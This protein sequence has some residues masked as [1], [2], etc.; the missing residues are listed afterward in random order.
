MSQDTTLPAGAL[1]RFLD[2]DV[3]YSFRRSP[4]AMVAA[5]TALLC[6]VAALGAPWLAPHD[7]YDL[8]AIDLA[9][10]RLPPAWMEGGSDRYWLGTDGQGRD[11]LSTIMYGTRISLFVGLAAV[12]ISV[13]LGVA[14]GLL[15]GF[16]GGRLDAF[17][18]RV[19]D[20]MLSFPA[21]LVAL[22]I[23][24][25]GRAMFPDAHDTLA[26]AV[27]ILA[28]AL[29]GWVKFARTV[30]GST[31]VE[32]HKEYVQAAR[33]IGVSRGRIML[34]HVLPNVTGPVLVLTT[35]DIGQAVLA[36]ATLSFLGVGVPPT[37][38]SL[39]TLIRI[40]NDFLFSGEW[41]ITIFPGV[42][43][44]LIALSVNLLG[45]WMRDAL[46]PRLR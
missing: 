9:D 8:A 22:L 7:P 25:A 40:G 38:P 44:V 26:F 35:I 4:V 46:N 12:A 27:L 18:M 37:S 3:W 10:A 36:E 11:I 32:R 17:V 21:L 34:R 33:V 45:D 23:D 2:G 14:L 20:V 13:L 41:W 31:M 16:V 24:G 42:M 19:C 5:L 30:R 6:I 15:S 29:T 28:I 39:G 43:L 1:A